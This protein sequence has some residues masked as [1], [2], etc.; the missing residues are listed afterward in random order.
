MVTLSLPALA[1]ALALL[2]AQALAPQP[3]RAHAIESSLEHLHHHGQATPLAAAANEADQLR[4]QSS[5]STGQPVVAAAVRLAPPNGAQPLELGRTDSAGQL[6]FTLPRQAGPDWEL[7]VDGGPG[8]R[9]YLELPSVTARAVPPAA[10]RS[11]LADATRQ[12]S[13]VA[14]IGG[15]GIGGLALRRRRG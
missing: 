3:V 7:Q 15:L 12:A 8:H 2:L 6:T 1:G 9:D 10:G 5:F 4:L 13:L 14:L 11:E